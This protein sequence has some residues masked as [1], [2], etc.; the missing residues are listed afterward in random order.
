MNK[1]TPIVVQ[2]DIFSSNLEVQTNSIKESLNKKYGKKY[3]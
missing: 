2:I 3:D 1:K